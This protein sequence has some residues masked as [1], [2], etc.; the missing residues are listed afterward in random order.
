[1][2]AAGCLAG[3]ALCHAEVPPFYS[4]G[5]R[6][7]EDVLAAGVMAFHAPRYAGSDERRSIVLPSAT[8]ILANGL[9]ADPISGIGFNASADPRVEAGVRATIGLGREEI[10]PLRGLGRIRDSLNV[11]GFAN[12]NVTDS[13]QLQSALRFGS[14]N[15]R[16]G[17]LLDAGASCEF[18]KRGHVSASIEGSLSYANGPYMRSY[19]GVDAAQSAASG[20]GGYRPGAGLQWRS[21]GLAFQA[22]VH[23]RALAFLTVEYTRL[24]GVAAA[25]PLVRKAGALSVQA[26]VSYGF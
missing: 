2:L 18:F 11:G 5:P 14:G 1:M 6:P 4:L 22:P 26:N 24:A 23:P 15:G 3:A 12:V 13:I 8:A 21:A 17:L 20:Y 25:S 10:G 16:D 7:A 9:F 19:Y